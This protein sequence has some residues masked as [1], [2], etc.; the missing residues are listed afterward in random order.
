MLEMIGKFYILVIWIFEWALGISVLKFNS[1]AKLDG[2]IGGWTIIRDL[3][4]LV[5]ILALFYIAIGT[6]LQLSGVDWKK[7]WRLHRDRK[8]KSN[9]SPEPARVRRR[10]QRWG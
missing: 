1:F 4:N 9:Q 6:I 5:F 3:M 7:G 2:I 8:M 10:L